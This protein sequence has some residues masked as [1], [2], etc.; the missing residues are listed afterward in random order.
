M[1]VVLLVFINARM[2]DVLDYCLYLDEQSETL[3]IRET[4][5][6]HRCDNQARLNARCFEGDIMD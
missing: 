6:C 4:D 1:C 2:P 3:S 5:N